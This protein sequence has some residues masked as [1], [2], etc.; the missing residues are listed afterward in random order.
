MTGVAHRT[1]SFSH[2]PDPEGLAGRFRLL[3]LSAAALTLLVLGIILLLFPFPSF[4]LYLPI[5]LFVIGLAVLSGSIYLPQR[6]VPEMVVSR[7]PEGSAES[8]LPP[9]SRPLA[10][11][12]APIGDRRRAVGTGAGADWRILSA[13]TDPGDETWLSWLPRERRR[14]GPADRGLAPGVVASPG[15]AGNLVAFPVRDYF[16]A[17][18]PVPRTEHRLVPPVRR[19]SQRASPFD[20]SARPAGQVP[21]GPS[22]DASRA[23]PSLHPFSEEE[24]D[25]MFPPE[26]D[27]ASR[28]LS[29]PPDRVG[30]RAPWTRAS[31]PPESST[32]AE[33]DSLESDRSATEST[34]LEA[35]IVVRRGNPADRSTD[36][37]PDIG[38]QGPRSEVLEDAEVPTDSRPNELSREAANPVPPHL[39]A[40]GPLIRFD[41][42]A[43]RPGGKDPSASRSVCASCSKV[44]VNLRMSGP[45]PRCLRPVCT[46]CLREAFVNQGHGWCLD[47]STADAS[48][49]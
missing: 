43:S 20:P 5:A 27:R 35:D 33:E 10:R 22:M 1:V 2:P 28:L 21:T 19:G 42:R 13:P 40:A 6:P 16:G 11:P 29:H 25:R 7:S 24:L 44:V 38:L 8:M 4:G 41:A 47:C 37:R 18:P 48:A 9:S 15:R 32:V 31:S 3:L 36:S 30:G 23:T 39:R 17:V 34:G 26:A 45:C 49:S 14:L 46:D 12:S